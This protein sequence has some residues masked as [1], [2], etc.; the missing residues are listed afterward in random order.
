[1]TG[2]RSIRIVNRW[3]TRYAAPHNTRAMPASAIS[4]PAMIETA[5][6]IS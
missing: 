4:A 6:D 5:R 1:M 3:G 2:A